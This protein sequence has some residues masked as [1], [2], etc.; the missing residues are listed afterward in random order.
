MQHLGMDNGAK[1]RL[2]CLS[3]LD[4][5]IGDASILGGDGDDDVASLP[6]KSALAPLL[7]RL[8]DVNPEVRHRSMH[9]LTRVGL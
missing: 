3:V 2:R 6:L 1:I 9:I 4:D 8:G 7:E 5:S